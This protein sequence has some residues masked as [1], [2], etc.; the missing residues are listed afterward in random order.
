MSSFA[1]RL[2]DW[3]RQHGRHDLPWQNTKDPYRVWLSEIML[4]QTQVDTVRGYYERFLSHFPT[5]QALA[6]ASEEAVLAQWSGLGYYARARNL[7]RAAQKV[8]ADFGGEFPRT[9]AQLIELP[10]IGRS[11]SAAISSFC[12]GQ[13]AA[14]LDGNVKRVLTRHFGVEGFP[15]ERAVELQLW[16]LAESLLPDQDIDIYTQAQMDL[17]ASLCSRTKPQ[18]LH[19]PLSQTCVARAQGR[20]AELPTAKPKKGALPQREKSVLLLRVGNTV[21]LEKRAASGIWGGLYS[22]PE[23]NEGESA[24]ALA[25]RRFGINELGACAP[26]P[27]VRHVFTHFVLTLTAHQANLPKQ[28]LDAQEAGLIWGDLVALEMIGLPAPIKRL[29]EGL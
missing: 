21:L 16:A 9:S 24:Q 11:T 20:Q 22:L 10:G 18:C 27:P 29:L 28:P 25:Q 8:V 6:Q 13:K 7:H 5:V 15:G 17:G 3:Q 19:C 12:F 1:T 26:L 23:M 2:I 14:I 4:Q